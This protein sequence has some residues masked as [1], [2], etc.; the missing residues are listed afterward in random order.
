MMHPKVLDLATIDRE[1][2]IGHV[3]GGIVADAGN[4]GNTGA[5]G[6]VFEVVLTP[7]DLPP[8]LTISTSPG[9][10]SIQWPAAAEHRYLVEKSPDLGSWTEA[11]QPLSGTG[12]LEWSEPRTT[13]AAFF[14]VLSGSLSREPAP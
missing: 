13:P 14:R 12:I 10:V 9:Q 7:L 5:S 8:A 4:G 1:K 2:V 11:T 3:F 6:R